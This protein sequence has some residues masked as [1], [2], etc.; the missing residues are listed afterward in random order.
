MTK[1]I[2]NKNVNI[3]NSS[4]DIIVG[5]RLYK[6]TIVVRLIQ[7]KTLWNHNENKSVVF[8]YDL[9]PFKTSVKINTFSQ[10]LWNFLPRYRKINEQYFGELFQDKVVQDFDGINWIF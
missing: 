6:V 10:S 5:L 9:Y 2:F 3:L 8:H 7:Y 1:W 4:K